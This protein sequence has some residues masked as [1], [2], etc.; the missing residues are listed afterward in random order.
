MNKI[1][2]TYGNLKKHPSERFQGGCFP[3]Y[4]SRTVHFSD[5]GN[6]FELESALRDLGLEVL[7]A[8]ILPA[9][10][11]IILDPPS[12]KDLPTTITIK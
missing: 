10:S 12:L 11:T 9:R 1:F 2:V 5:R 3:A 6:I 4:T 7:P 8:T